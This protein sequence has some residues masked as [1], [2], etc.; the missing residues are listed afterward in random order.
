[1]IGVIE[2]KFEKKSNHELTDKGGLRVVMAPSQKT[3]TLFSAS[4][5]LLKFKFKVC[6][7][8]ENIQIL[9]RFM[10]PQLYE[11][12]NLLHVACSMLSGTPGLS[13]T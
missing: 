2:I 1:M 4:V 6:V 3:V 8:M 5:K 7:L 13:G 12:A 9:I 10:S 11:L